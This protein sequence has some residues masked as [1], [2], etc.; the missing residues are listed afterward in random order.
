[1]RKLIISMGQQEFV[2]WGTYANRE[3]M[4]CW[5]L[6]LS[7]GW[8][9]KED[10]VDDF[11][12][13]TSLLRAIEKVN[14]NIEQVLD[15]FILRMP[16]LRKFMILHSVFPATYNRTHDWL[17]G[18]MVRRLMP[19]DKEVKDW[20][21]VPELPSELSEQFAAFD[22]E[23]LAPNMQMD[24]VRIEYQMFGN[25]KRGESDNPINV[26]DTDWEQMKA[27]NIAEI[28]KRMPEIDLRP[29]DNSPVPVSR[30]REYLPD[31]DLPF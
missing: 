12:K 3:I 4:K 21:F 2:D 17:Q 28:I 16:D 27:I 10:G 11:L 9:K 7:I 29:N 26:I 25:V 13:M 31:D 24:N 8:C 15:S 14:E 5:D 1:L 19:T 18:Y 30:T 22:P 20:L 6:Y 23:P